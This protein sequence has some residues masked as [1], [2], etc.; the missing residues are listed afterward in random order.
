MSLRWRINRLRAMGVA[1][2]SSRALQMLRA[3]LE[4]H[5]I[6][7]TSVAVPNHIAGATW[8][9]VLPKTF[10]VA[11]YTAE[12]DRILGGRFHVFAL[13][14]APLG[15]PPDWNRDP[16][17][18][19]RA[20]MS[21]GKLLDY[22]DARLVGDVKYLW[23][24]NRH[25][26]LVTLAQAWHLSRDPR[27]ANACGLFIDSWLLACPYPRGVN[28]TSS[29]EL[30]LRLVNWSFAWHL[31]GGETAVV[32]ADDAGQALRLRWLASVRQHC[33]FIAGHLSRHSSANNH[34]LGELLGLFV[35]A[36][37]WPL[38][39]GKRTLA[40]PRTRGVRTRSASPKRRGWRQ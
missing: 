13:A 23:E 35:A 3:R 33:H 2:I 30:A 36:T 15:F 7:L 9:S 16:K 19:T 27:Y 34:L 38:W 22:R 25:A 29:L 6:G 12:A 24:P 8:L 39:K 31:L 40:R 18:G 20:P 26:E 10:N 1:E 37:T 32:F 21:F 14:A 17:T 28:W 11:T 4:Q 5:G